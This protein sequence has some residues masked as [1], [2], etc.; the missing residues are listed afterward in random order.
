MMWN[1]RIIRHKKDDTVW[2]SVHEVFYSENGGI[3][4]FTEEPIT[5]LG[6]TEED[7]KTQLE[8]IMKD[9]E[10]HEVLDASTVKFEDWY[11][12]EIEKTK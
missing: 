8:M 1:N 9:I 3:N 10:K 4:G 5:I 12:E 2:H 6:E 11:D 7:V